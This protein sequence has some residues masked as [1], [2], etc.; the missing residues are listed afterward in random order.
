MLAVVAGLQ[1]DI[2]GFLKIGR[3]DESDR[4]R[5]LRFYTSG[6]LPQVVA[7]A[8]GFS[9]EGAERSVGALLSRFNADVIVSAGFASSASHDLATGEIVVCDRILAVDGPAYS[10]RMSDR[11][12]IETNPSVVGRMRRQMAAADVKFKVGACV[13]LPQTVVNSPM[14]EWLG[15]TFEAAAADLDGYWIARVVQEFRLPCVPVRAIVDTMEQDVSLRAVEALRQ[16]P[17]RRMLRSLGYVSVNP[18][19]LVE[20]SKLST[21]AGK[22]RKS[23]AQFLYRLARSR[24]SMGEN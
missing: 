15:R 21:Q 18:A 8:G 22:A 20:V 3:F 23:L 12:E 6:S 24:F 9:G 16:P 10:W 7:A 17:A 13:T 1:R 14:K 2:A 11:R 4:E 19:R 5:D